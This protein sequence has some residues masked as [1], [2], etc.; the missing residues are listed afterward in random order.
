M[1]E[2]GE[3]VDSFL[4]ALHC[5]AE[6]CDYGALR[7]QMIR[8][9]LVVGLHDAALAEKLQLE[10]ELKLED[11]VKR[12]RNSEAVKGQQSTVRGSADTSTHTAGAVGVVQSRKQ[13][14]SGQG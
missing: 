3:K 8:D 14:R 1:Q 11:A 9:R 6:R 5:L 7:E 13:K 2:P 4:T 10:S 12:A